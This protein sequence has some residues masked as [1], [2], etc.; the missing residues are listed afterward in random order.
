VHD[1]SGACKLLAKKSLKM[2]HPDIHITASYSGQRFSR[3]FLA[4]APSSHEVHGFTKSILKATAA[5]SA[6]A[7]KFCFYRAIPG[8][9]LANF[10]GITC[11][12]LI[13]ITGSADYLSYGHLDLT[14]TRTHSFYLEHSLISF[15]IAI[16]SLYTE[17]I[18]L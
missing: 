4:V 18:N 16:Y 10:L 17:L 6:Q 9:K 2:D 5:A 11:N 8:I 12:C 7:S 1:A 3:L 15:F 14:P 13:L